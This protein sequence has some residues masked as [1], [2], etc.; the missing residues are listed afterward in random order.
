[1]AYIYFCE[2]EKKKIIDLFI[3][4]MKTQ[5]ILDAIFVEKLGLGAQQINANLRGGVRAHN[6]VSLAWHHLCLMLWRSPNVV[7]LTRNPGLLF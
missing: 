7:A 5:Y 4:K 2:K 3:A 1:M 6:C